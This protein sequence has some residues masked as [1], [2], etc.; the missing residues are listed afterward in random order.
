VRV[1]LTRLLVAVVIVAAL[2]GAT[3]AATGEGETT[4]SSGAT[5]STT[6]AATTDVTKINGRE[7]TAVELAKIKA[8]V[9]A[10]ERAKIK[11]WVEAV[12]RHKIRMWVQAVERENARRWFAWA[13]AKE[14]A[15]AAAAA[16]S[17]GTLVQGIVVCNGRDLP[18]C[19][20]V[21]RESGFNPRAEN[22]TSTASGLYQFID[23][24][25]R[26]CGT[27]YGHASYAPVSVQVQ[28][29]RKIWANGA[30]AGHWRLTY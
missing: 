18:T 29:A 5:T 20:I 23:G 3:S 7:Y 13:L 28:C 30:G 14:R 6:Q 17:G 12:Q 27:G 4:V 10:V 1:H 15:A 9:E 24:T 8:W 21:K 19:G 22:P 11:G 2:A 26:T 25:W 16:A